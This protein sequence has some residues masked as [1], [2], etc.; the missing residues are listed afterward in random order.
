MEELT[1]AR[2]VAI[3]VTVQHEDRRS[4]REEDRK[5]VDRRL[6]RSAVRPWFAQP[7]EEAG[8]ALPLVGKR[9]GYSFCR[10]DHIAVRAWGSDHPSPSGGRGVA[11]IEAF[12]CYDLGLM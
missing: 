2:D 5:A 12:R 8:F 4:E 9:A 6:A 1:P 11:G 3:R 7:P 10:G